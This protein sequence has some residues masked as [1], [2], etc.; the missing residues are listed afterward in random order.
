[1]FTGIIKEL[2]KVESISSLGGITKLSVKGSTLIKDTEIGDSIA[3]NGV[4]L[5]VTDIKEK[6]IFFDLSDET[7]KRTNIGKLKKGDYVNLE[8]SLKLSDKLGGH[9]V[10]GHIDTVGKIKSKRRIGDSIY[11]EIEVSDEI[12]EFI[13][14][15]GS[16]AVDGISLTV[17]DV[18]KS[19]F[20]VTIIPYTAMVTTIGYKNINDTV[21]I[22]VDIIGK[23][24]R[25]FL[26]KETN[27][28]ERLIKKLKKGN[29]IY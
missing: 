16:I 13:V 26:S 23:Y 21:N 27:S 5:T 20:T 7:V 3:V 1:M 29:F 10:T 9:I 25:K 17:V 19:Y 11:I 24:V 8:P 28:E 4:C 14:E 2:A 6:I 18:S 15:K 12:M 22:E